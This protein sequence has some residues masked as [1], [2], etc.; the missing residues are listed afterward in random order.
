[1]QVKIDVE[2]E[3]KVIAL[4]RAGKPIEAVALVQNQ[5]QVGLKNSKDIVDK[6]AESLQ[7]TQVPK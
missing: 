4:I 7:S 1:M 3:K 2:L 5:M 6:L